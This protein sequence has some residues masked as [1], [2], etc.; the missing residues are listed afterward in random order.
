VLQAGAASFVGLRRITPHVDFI[1]IV[2]VLFTVA[3][4]IVTTRNLAT[5]WRSP[6]LVY[7]VDGFS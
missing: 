2:P 4:S 6:A 3:S 1:F 7:C 5:L